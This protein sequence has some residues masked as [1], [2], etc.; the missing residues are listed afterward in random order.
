MSRTSPASPGASARRPSRERYDL[1][2]FETMAATEPPRFSLGV[3]DRPKPGHRRPAIAPQPS[4]RGGIDAVGKIEPPR[5]RIPAD[6]AEHGVGI[7][8]EAGRGLAGAVTG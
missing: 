1:L 2:T 4:R 3:G 7:E 6:R 5:R 8:R